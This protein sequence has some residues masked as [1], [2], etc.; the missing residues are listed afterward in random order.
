MP[1]E[2]SWET[3][4]EAEDLYITGG[5]TYEQVSKRTG[6]SIA[7]LKRWGKDGDWKTKKEEC[8]KALSEIKQKKIKLRLGLIEKA[9]E[10]FDPQQ[11]FAVSSIETIELKAEEE[12]RKQEKET[13][14]KINFDSPSEYLE[15]LQ[16]AI[17]NKIGRMVYG[18]DS[19]DLK[20]IKDLKAARELIKDMKSEYLPKG[21]DTKTKG[22]TEKTIEGMMKLLMGQND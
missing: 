11:A 2:I 19:L 21:D 17:E 10:G 1:T 12:R 15:A 13:S 14:L 4:I 9:M 22:I 3:R 20:S 5:N 6:V 16:S 18:Q 7:Q 8:L